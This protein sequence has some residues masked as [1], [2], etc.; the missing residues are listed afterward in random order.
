[1]HLH[2]DKQ[3]LVNGNSSQQRTDYVSGFRCQPL[4]AGWRSGAAEEKGFLEVYPEAFHTRCCQKSICVVHSGPQPAPCP[5]PPLP[6]S[7]FLCHSSAVVSP[8]SLSL[9]LS[10]LFTAAVPLPISPTLLK[11]PVPSL[12]CLCPSF[13]LPTLLLSSSPYSCPAP[14]HLSPICADIPSGL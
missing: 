5:C 14:S 9:G 8:K 7:F 1:M 10:P 13:L 2:N 6:V 12:L 4:V 11:S 3:R